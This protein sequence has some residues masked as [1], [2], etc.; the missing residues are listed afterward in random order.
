[1]PDTKF[2][3]KRDK[4]LGLC[5]PGGLILTITFR[6]AVRLSHASVQPPTPART[7]THVRG[8]RCFLYSL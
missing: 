6:S 1:M 2:C 4:R 3:K 8:S 5:A 7:H